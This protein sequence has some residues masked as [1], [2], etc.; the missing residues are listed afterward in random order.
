MTRASMIGS[1]TNDATMSREELGPIARFR[2]VDGVTAECQ[3]IESVRSRTCAAVPAPSS[4]STSW[5]R[6]R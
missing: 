3:G 4:Q 5:C 1:S 6:S 2:Y